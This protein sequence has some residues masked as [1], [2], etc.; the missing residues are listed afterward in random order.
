MSIK[1]NRIRIFLTFL[2]LFFLFFQ[3]SVYQ[4]ASGSDL[5]F[6]YILLLITLLFYLP[7]VKKN[8]QLNVYNIYFLTIIITTIIAVINYGIN[9]RIIL[10]LFAYASFLLGQLMVIR[11]GSNYI[12]HLLKIVAY[13]IIAFI[14]IRFIIYFQEFIFSIL[15]GNRHYLRIKNIPFFAAGGWNL[16][17]TLIGFLSLVFL[18][19]KLGYL[20]L[21]LC[22]LLTVIYQSR[23]GLIIALFSFILTFITKKQETSNL[24]SKIYLML[25]FIISALLFF[26][27]STEIEA[28]N[29]LMTR[30]FDF[31]TEIQFFQNEQGRLTLYFYGTKAWL[32][33]IFGYGIG[34]AI[35]VISEMSNL[36][37]RE[38]NLHNI[39]LQNL[40]EGGIQSF[41]LLFYIFLLLLQKQ[42]RNN[43]SDPFG[44]IALAYFILGFVQ[45]TG[46][47]VIGW[48]F[49]GLS[50]CY[51]NNSKTAQFYKIDCYNSNWNLR[52]A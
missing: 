50:S 32:E 40:L 12:I 7:P 49:L 6:Y 25:I 22:V 38:N 46:Y 8:I 48:F 29:N 44:R 33:N 10:I 34:N 30:F 47:D 20:L 5:R 18:N 43:F 28:V 31:N 35:P 52:S 42:I 45:Y 19:K 17:V 14:V 9:E 3:I 26:L 41:I 36:T 27:F 13:F 39:Y 1:L 23:V 24:I 16:E 15:S 37:F 11:L 21:F 4:S 51:E 2:F